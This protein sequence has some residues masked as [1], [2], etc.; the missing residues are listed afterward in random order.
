M[1]SNQKQIIYMSELYFEDNHLHSLVPNVIDPSATTIYINSALANITLRGSTFI[2]NRATKIRYPI[3]VMIANLVNE[4]SNTYL[5]TNMVEFDWIKRIEEF[6]FDVSTEA[7]AKQHLEKFFQI[8]SIGGNAMIKA[9]YIDLKSSFFNEAFSTSG[10]G[11]YLQLID[12]GYVNIEG[13]R[14]ENQ[15]TDLADQYLSK[16]GCL[17]IDSSSS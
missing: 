10:T 3:I 6:Q 15:Y 8:E 9:Q 11:L 17:Y 16:G 5:K 14:F 1:L 7:K 13:S 12:T 4:T 2:K